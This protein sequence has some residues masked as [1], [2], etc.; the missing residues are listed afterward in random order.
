[1]AIRTGESGSFTGNNKVVP[2]LTHA[3]SGIADMGVYQKPFNFSKPYTRIRKNS[4][5]F[6]GLKIPE[7]AFKTEKSGD[8][9]VL[10]HPPGLPHI[11]LEEVLIGLPIPAGLPFAAGR[12]SGAALITAGT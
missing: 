1:M 4:L 5:I 11:I 2:R 10:I 12:G 9:S 7:R 6:R 8:F 3:F